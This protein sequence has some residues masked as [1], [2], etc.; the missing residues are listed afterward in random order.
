M[1]FIPIWLVNLII[2]IA[3][4]GIITLSL[5]LEVGYTGLPQFGRTI[6]VLGGAFVAG[7]IPGRLLAL[8]WAIENWELFADSRYNIGIVTSIN[9][10]LVA[11]PIIALIYMLVT[12]I[13]AAIVGGF[14]GWLTSRPA[15]RLKEAY[16]GISLLSIGDIIMY[17]GINFDPLVGGTIPVK[18]PDP[19][20]WICQSSTKT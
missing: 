14:L 12:L 19:F 6:A 9:Q 17:T 15:V 16:L 20:A 7:S 10:I 1:S 3:I 8:I 2:D 5:N 11:N 18:V 4:F 13:L